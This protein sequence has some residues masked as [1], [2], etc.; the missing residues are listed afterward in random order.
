MAER[1]LGFSRLPVC[2]QRIPVS[3]SAWWQGIQDGRYPP[4]FHL[5]KRTTAWR[6]ADLDELE[7]L[8]AQGKDWRDREQFADQSSREAM[9]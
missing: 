3:R 1:S 2:L 6:N 7:E 8:I 9:A 5:S 4:A